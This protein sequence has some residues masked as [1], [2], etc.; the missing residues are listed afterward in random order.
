MRVVMI[1]LL[2]ILFHLT[3][4][5]RSQHIFLILLFHLT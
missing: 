2:H 1:I 5:T 4:I 3:Q